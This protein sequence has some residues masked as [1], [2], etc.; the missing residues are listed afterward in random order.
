MK[1]ADCPVRPAWLLRRFRSITD[2][3][4]VVK[5]FDLQPIFV[6]YPVKHLSSDN[7]RELN[8]FRDA[9][10]AVK[11]DCPTVFVLYELERN[12][13]SLENRY[14]GLKRDRA[15]RNLFSPRL[16]FLSR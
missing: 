3:F 16:Y 1:R 7:R 2:H 9:I 6:R 10:L 5:P 13:V 14:Y 8:S 15:I 4:R 12:A 11:H